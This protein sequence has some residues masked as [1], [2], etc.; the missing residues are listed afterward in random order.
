[1]TIQANFDPFARSLQILRCASLVSTEL[2]KLVLYQLS[3]HRRKHS[4]QRSRRRVESYHTSGCIQA[5]R[6]VTP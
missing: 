6:Q 2:G 1:M 3:Y 5:S 4:E